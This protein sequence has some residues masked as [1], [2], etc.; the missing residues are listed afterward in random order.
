MT[1]PQWVA[2]GTGAE[3]NH[4]AGPQF[5]PGVPGAAPPLMM[6]F[7]PGIIPLRPLGLGDLYGAAVKAVR[8]NVGATV[9]LALVT[10]LIFLVPTTALGAW[11]ASLETAPQQSQAFPVL[12]MLGGYVP[13]VGTSLSSILLSGFLAFVIG[14]AVRGRRVSAVQTWEGTRGRL[15]PLVGATLVASVSIVVAI[16][17]LLV[18]PVLALVGAI[19][20]AETSNDPSGVIGAVLLLL[21]ALLVAAVVTLY[22]STRLAFVAPTEVLEQ[23]GVRGGISRSWRLTSGREFWRVLG[24]R[25]LTAIIVGIAAQVVTF[26][27]SMI[28]AI[29]ILGTT[30]PSRLYVWQAIVAGVGGLVAGAL[31]TPFTAGID[32]LLYVDQ[33]IRREGFDVRLIAAVQE[34][35]GAPGRP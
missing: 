28:G 34:D 30:D 10:T 6:E 13:S 32:A 20:S 14:Q 27:L 4:G 15:M 26:P 29:G 8:G 33:R 12:G 24:I 35:A 2:P 1:D 9:G 3:P 25:L 11:V 19:Q 22:L 18:A 17:I 7:R 31:T 5:G 23:L 21:G 16:G